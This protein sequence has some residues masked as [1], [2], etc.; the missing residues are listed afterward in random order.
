MLDKAGQQV[1]HTTLVTVQSYYYVVGD[2]SMLDYPLFYSFD[3]WVPPRREE[4]PDGWFTAVYPQVR[5]RQAHRDDRR[6]E[7]VSGTS[8]ETLGDKVKELDKMCRLSK[9]AVPSRTA[10]IVPKANADWVSLILY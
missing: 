7:A 6:W 4:I 2:D 3:E 8:S 1:V 9:Y 10:H 5:V